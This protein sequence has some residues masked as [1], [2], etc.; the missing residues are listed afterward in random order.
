MKKIILM[1]SFTLTLFLSSCTQDSFETSVDNPI[2]EN[3]QSRS[4]YSREGLNDETLKA[5]LQIFYDQNKNYAERI[6]QILNQNPNFK[7]GNDF[8]AEINQAQSDNDII[9]TFSKY[10]VVDN[11]QELLNLIKE[12]DILSEEFSNSNPYLYQLDESTR[13]QYIN[14]IVL[15][16]VNNESIM[17]KP[18]CYQQYQMDRTR[19][20]RNYAAASVV[21]VASAP[22]TAGIV[23]AIVGGGAVALYAFCLGDANEDYENCL[24]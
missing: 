19:C 18:T 23:T 5:N 2:I 15:N 17:A 12:K 9:Q 20:Y 11:A 21:A 8:Y 10:G 24:K 14:E 22:F 13:E 16:D 6:G 4:Q 3:K 7:G 1:S